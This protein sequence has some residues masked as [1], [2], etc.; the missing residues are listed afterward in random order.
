MDFSH[1]QLQGED[2]IQ[3]LSQ[4]PSLLSLSMNGNPMTSEVAHFRKK[5]IVANKRLRYL[6]RPVFD[7]E[8]A[9]S[10]AWSMGGR[11]A[12]LKT[13]LE[14]KEK[15][16][17]D[18]ARGMESFRKWQME[19]R[20]QAI[21]EKEAIKAFGPTP[22][23]LAK[24]EQVLLKKKEREEKAAQ[25]AAREREIYRLRDVDETKFSSNLDG[26]KC[27]CYD[28]EVCRHIH[29]NDC[30][31]KDEEI[32]HSSKT[33]EANYEKKE[34]DSPT[35]FKSEDFYYSDSS[36]ES[37]QQKRDDTENKKVYDATDQTFNA[38]NNSDADH[39]RNMKHSPTVCDDSKFVE[40]N[41]GVMQDALNGIKIH[42]AKD[43]SAQDLSAPE[44]NATNRVKEDD[45]TPTSFDESS[46]CNVQGTSPHNDFDASKLEDA[47]HKT[48]RSD[49]P[50][51]I[52][53]T[54]FHDSNPSQA[55]IHEDGDE[56]KNCSNHHSCL[57]ERT[58][59]P[60]ILWTFQMDESLKELTAQHNLNFDH[61]SKDISLQYDS[62]EW[63]AEICRL[64]WCHLVDLDCTTV[65]TSRPLKS[66]H[67]SREDQ[68]RASFD[69]LMF[70]SPIASVRPSSFPTMDDD[71][72]VEDS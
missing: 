65:T 58:H 9:S 72:S 43:T 71:S 68:Q 25:D 30:K 11:D 67:S 56:L 55:D 70:G 47:I 46:Q 40:S 53:H 27:P 45:E 52:S 39:E 20:A 66:F 59:V 48:N 26:G 69:E 62:V 23:Q 51:T 34:G 13:Q 54:G 2:I 21:S 19:L 29:G 63:N 5:M 49:S 44:N 4:V 18:E 15:K 28:V 57:Q 10:E 12:E 38:C 41:Q 32:C 7:M 1:N 50:I 24:Q 35:S 42:D 36:H 64:R 16:Q 6:D 60:T 8:R 37:T 14:W 33:E 17:Q 22:T 31:E 61:V 3:T